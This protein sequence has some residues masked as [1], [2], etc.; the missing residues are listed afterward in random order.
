MVSAAGSREREIRRGKAD[1]SMEGMLRQRCRPLGGCG[2][3]E[4]LEWRVTVGGGGNPRG[5]Q[6]ARPGQARLSWQGIG[7][8]ETGACATPGTELVGSSWSVS[9][10]CART[11]VETVHLGTGGALQA[12][13]PRCKRPFHPR[14]TNSSS[15]SHRTPSRCVPF[16]GR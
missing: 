10:V 13:L 1:E 5:D 12:A 14:C 6:E 8:K 16:T 11:E 2:F 7:D 3:V 9:G 15:T 4:A